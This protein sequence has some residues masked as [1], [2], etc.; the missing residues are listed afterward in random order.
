MPLQ[1]LYTNQYVVHLKLT[2]CSTSIISQLKKKKSK[3]LF[4][5]CLPVPH[6][7][8]SVLF[9]VETLI[10]MPI[11]WMRKLRFQRWI[12]LPGT[13]LS[14]SSVLAHTHVQML[15]DTGLEIPSPTPVVLTCRGPPTA[16]R[17]QWSCSRN[18]PWT[19]SPATTNS[20]TRPSPSWV[21]LQGC[22]LRLHPSLLNGMSVCPSTTNTEGFTTVSS[23]PEWTRP[24]DAQG[25]AGSAESCRPGGRKPR[26][27]NT[28]GFLTADRHSWDPGLPL[29]LGLSP[30]PFPTRPPLLPVIPQPPGWPHLTLTQSLSH[31]PEASGDDSG[32]DGRRK[33]P[34]FPSDGINHVV[35]K[36]LLSTL[37]SFTWSPNV[38]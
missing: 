6:T 32:G 19:A 20:S 17:R 29:E 38:C 15:S 14:L 2:Q 25:P 33:A 11:S 13:A 35:A 3:F 27:P 26:L 4:I 37:A 12:R 5:E 7:Q 36:C 18:Q 30:S 10:I 21:A 16:S 34:A 28:P 8:Y 31:F 23:M 22:L 9:P 24:Q 1:Y